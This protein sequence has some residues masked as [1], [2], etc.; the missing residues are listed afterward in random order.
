M[1]PAVVVP[2]PWKAPALEDNVNLGLAQQ[3]TEEKRL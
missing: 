2:F 3:G 1:I